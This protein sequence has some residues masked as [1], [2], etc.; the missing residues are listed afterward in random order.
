MAVYFITTSRL[1]K[2]AAAKAEDIHQNGISLD[3]M[4]LNTREYMFDMNAFYKVCVVCRHGF[5]CCITIIHYQ[6]TVLIFYCWQ[7]ILI[8]DNDETATPDPSKV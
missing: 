5:S 6:L 1:Q 8:P 3:L 7:D 2:Q 4:H